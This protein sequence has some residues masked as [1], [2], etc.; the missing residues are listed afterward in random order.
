MMM[1]MMLDG[2]FKSFI[3]FGFFNLMHEVLIATLVER[4]FRMLQQPPLF[5]MSAVVTALAFT[6]LLQQAV[7]GIFW[8]LQK[9]L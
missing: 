9:V 2:R 3:Y 6:S 8:R 1:L 5:Y 7:L 4:Y